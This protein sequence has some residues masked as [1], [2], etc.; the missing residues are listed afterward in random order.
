MP[1]EDPV[2]GLGQ[3]KLLF[4]LRGYKLHGKWTLVKIKKGD[5]EWLLIKE[6]DAYASAQGRC[7]PEESVLSGLSVEDLKA[8]RTPADGITCGAGTARCSEEGSPRRDRSR[9]CWP[10]R[11]TAVLRRGLALRAQARWL[12]VAGGTRATRAASLLPQRERLHPSFPEVDSRG[13]RAA[14]EP[15]AARRRGGGAGRVRARPASSGCSSGQSS[16]RGARYPPG[17]GGE[18]GHLLRLRS[19]RP[20]KTTTCGRCRWRQGRSCSGSC[21]RRRGSSDISITSRAKGRF[22]TSRFGSLVSKGSWPSGR[23]P[24]IGRAARRPGS[25]SGLARSDDFVVVGFTTPKGGRSGFGAL[26]LAP[27][28][29]WRC[30]LT[31]AGRG[32]DSPDAQLAE[33][34]GTLD[35]HPSP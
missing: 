25:R 24:L 14:L 2:A 15:V 1:V 29:G 9:S 6:R 13:G 22:C 33:V 26:Q 8:G 34:R 3:G 23:T 31:A 19:P 4:E 21:C 27:V 11:E 28:C 12:P 17:G 30:S 35:E 18:P 7:P 32:A 5:K 20:S 16:R 10:S